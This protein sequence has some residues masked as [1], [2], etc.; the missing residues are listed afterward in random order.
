MR[1]N[2]LAILAFAGIA[3]Y[4]TG[5]WAADY[6]AYCR[7]KSV[8]VCALPGAVPVCHMAI[9]IAVVGALILVVL[10]TAGEYALGIAHEQ[11]TI[12]GIFL[13]AMIGASFVE[14]ILFRGYLVVKN[15]GRL[16]L[17]SSI[18]VFS[19]CFALLHPHLWTYQSEAAWWQFWKG[20]WEWHGTTKGIFSTL[21]LFFNALWFYTVRFMP[22]NRQHSLIP[23]FA[24]HLSSNLA[25]FFIK[26]STGHVAG[27]L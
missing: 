8:S 11:T 15:H 20:Q 13:V 12:H 7:G 27:L 10:E 18:L 25:V 4:L 22:I 17:I 9:F 1:E 3:I 26:W 5:L 24:A 2:S 19:L 23:C 6:R 14:E 16:L 21:F